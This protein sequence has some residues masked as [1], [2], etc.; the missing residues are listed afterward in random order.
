MFKGVHI[1]PFIKKALQLIFNHC[2]G[3][4]YEYFN[5]QS[6]SLRTWC[7]SAGRWR[8]SNRFCFHTV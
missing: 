1:V 4:R 3:S 5:R 6:C 7:S 2:P 8:I